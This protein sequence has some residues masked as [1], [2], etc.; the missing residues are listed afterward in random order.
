M[1][2]AKGGFVLLLTLF[3]LALAGLSCDSGL[4]SDYGP[5]RDSGRLS[6]RNTERNFA[7]TPRPTDPF[8]HIAEGWYYHAANHYYAVVGR[9][10]V[11][12]PIGSPV[13]EYVVLRFDRRPYGTTF[14]HDLTQSSAIAIW[15]QKHERPTVVICSL[16]GECFTVDRSSE[17]E[18]RLAYAGKAVLEKGQNIYMA[19]SWKWLRFDVIAKED[20]N[21]V[22]S[23]VGELSTLLKQ[24]NMAEAA[25]CLSGMLGE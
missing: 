17:H 22:I 1:T 5:P 11:T 2:K 25:E 6:P 3:A 9:R 23:I 7:W 18:M 15:D 16:I 19:S 13:L 10:G 8:C 14:I 20:K 24:E 21:R 12:I 4:P